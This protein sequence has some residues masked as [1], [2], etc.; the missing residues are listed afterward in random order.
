MPGEEKLFW[1]RSGPLLNIAVD[2]LPL[3]RA[4][5]LC[6]GSNFFVDMTSINLCF[7]H[8]SLEGRVFM[9]VAAVLEE[10]WTEAGNHTPNSPSQ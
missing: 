6:D 9:P 2:I 4:T 3:S 1:K 10:D 8:S 7:L 5:R